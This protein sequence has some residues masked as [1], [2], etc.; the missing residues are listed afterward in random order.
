MSGIPEGTMYDLLRGR[1]GSG[2]GGSGGGGCGGCLIR[3]MLI[4]LTLSG[5]VFVVAMVVLF[6]IM[7]GGVLFR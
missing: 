1:G 7:V 5:F 2:A 6:V 4:I 3:A